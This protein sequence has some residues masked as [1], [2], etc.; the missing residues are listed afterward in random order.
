MYLSNIEDIF[1]LDVGDKILG[2][3]EMRRGINKLSPIQRCEQIQM[4]ITTDLISKYK[5]S[6]RLLYLCDQLECT[7]I[8]KISQ[9]LLLCA[10]EF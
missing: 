9:L 2:A 3:K 7:A 4:C 1:K 8:A 6:N 10:N 5:I